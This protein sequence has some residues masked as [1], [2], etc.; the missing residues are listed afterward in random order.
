MDSD[1]ERCIACNSVIDERGIFNPYLCKN[2]EEEL[3]K[4]NPS[5]Q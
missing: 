4:I 5:R 1:Y 2:C 3:K